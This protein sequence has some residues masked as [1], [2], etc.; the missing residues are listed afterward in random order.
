M[1]NKT[2]AARFVAADHTLSQ[3]ALPL[4]PNEKL[5]RGKRLKGLRRLIVNLADRDI[6]RFMNVDSELDDFGGGF[7]L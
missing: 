7:S 6:L 4:H 1:E 5:V 3:Q 2:K